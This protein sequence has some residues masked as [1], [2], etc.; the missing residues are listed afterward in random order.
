MSSVSSL[1]RF[2][3]LMLMGNIDKLEE[4]DSTLIKMIGEMKYS[5]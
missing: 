4:L 5:E 2:L 1:I 3:I